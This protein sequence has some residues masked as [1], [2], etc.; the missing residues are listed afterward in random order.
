MDI[1]VPFINRNACICLTILFSWPQRKHARKFNMK[2]YYHRPLQLGAHW[3]HMNFSHKGSVM[4]T[5]FFGMIS[6]WCSNYMSQRT[7]TARSDSDFLGGRVQWYCNSQY[8]SK[9]T[10]S[11][12]Q[13][14]LYYHIN[15][16]I[17]VT[18][19]HIFE[20]GRWSQIKLTGISAAQGRRFV[21]IGLINKPS[22]KSMPTHW[23]FGL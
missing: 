15:I 3:W 11:K 23:H 8:S 12:Y 7:L 19:I 16:N 14:P 9:C 22:H 6:L 2:A 20:T 1:T 17:L 21:G 10:S 5:S 13:V 18:R 4:W